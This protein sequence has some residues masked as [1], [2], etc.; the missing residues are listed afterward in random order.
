MLFR[1]LGPGESYP[2]KAASQKV[3]IWSVSSVAYLQTPY[4]VPQENGN[5]L[6]TRWVKITNSRQQGRGIRVRRLCTANS[7]LFSF[8]ASR[9]SAETIQTAKHPAD[10]IEEDALLLRLDI[11]VAGVGTGACGPGVRPD[12]LVKCEKTQFAFELELL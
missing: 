6:D 9:H 10:L 8:A 2:D 1:S 12:F 11:K 5:R 7:E 4:D 3:G